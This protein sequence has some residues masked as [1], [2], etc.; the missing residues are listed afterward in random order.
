MTLE[1]FFSVTASNKMYVDHLRVINMTPLQRERH[2][3][4]K[5]IECGQI[6]VELSPEYDEDGCSGF[7][8][9]PVCWWCD[10]R[11]N[12][13]LQYVIPFNWR[14]HYVINDRAKQLDWAIADQEL[15]NAY[16]KAQHPKDDELPF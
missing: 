11:S 16:I 4:C 2:V 7:S 10:M 6:D 15:K 5:C 3:N 1:Q 14:I 8:A 9:E 12:S 13:R